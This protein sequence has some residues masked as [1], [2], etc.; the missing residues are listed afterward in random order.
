VSEIKVIHIMHGGPIKKISVNGRILTFEMHRYLGPVLLRAD[1]EPAKR[2]PKNFLHATSLWAQQGERMEGT[3]CRWDH[4][5]QPILKRDGRDRLKFV[6]W[7]PAVK[8]E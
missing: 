6:G 7:T 3:L 8:G 1:N 5:E 4:E 2:Q